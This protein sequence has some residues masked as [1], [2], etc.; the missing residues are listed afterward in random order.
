ME[1]KRG[2]LQVNDEMIARA[3][4]AAALGGQF[5]GERDVYAALGYKKRLEFD[6][7]FV[8]YL[9]QDIAKAIID[10]PV[11]RTW[12]GNL[13]VKQL[14]VDAVQERWEEL[15]RKLSIQQK[16]KR[17]DKLSQL[18]HYA[19]LLLGFSDVIDQTAWSNPVQPG[20]DLE[21]IKPLSEVSA[22]ISAYESDTKNP[23]FGLPIFY[24]VTIKRGADASEQ[25][26]NVHHTRV[27]HV[28]GE[29]LENEVEG[30]PYMQS[31]YNRLMDLEK[32]VGASAEMYWKGARP[33]YNAVQDK[34]YQS[35]PTL[36]NGI[37]EQIRKY[38]HGQSRFL[39][40]EGVNITALQ[41]QVK[42]PNH[43]VDVQ[44]QMICAVTNIPKRSLLGS[45]KGELSS[46]QDATEWSTFIKSRREE[47]A[48]AF[49]LIP[50]INKLIE[51]G[52]LVANK[53][54]YV[55]EWPDLFAPSELDKI[56]VGEKRSKA[57]Q[58]YSADPIAQMFMPK[59]SFY[60]L[61]LGLEEDQIDELM[62]AIQSRP[63]ID[64]EERADFE[65]GNDEN[66]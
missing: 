24:S 66:N 21:Y 26:F 48:N 2:D 53:N 15:D 31:L 41:Q 64:A 34:E 39:L 4:L 12:S 38:E 46:T 11:N 62:E 63:Q 1:R 61:I 56:A 29:V 51:V 47:F 23:R 50:F 65:D 52:V 55:I 10:R 35:S 27:L 37:K 5:D 3:Q 19:V 14:D 28:A 54:T 49:I 16:L 25:V 45:E 59:E 8:R 32:L 42:D 58:A 13:V 44:I 6:D 22:T 40:T 30:I 7:Y 9:R 57:L 60:K 20:V 43:A 36:E 18:G 33:G 17:L